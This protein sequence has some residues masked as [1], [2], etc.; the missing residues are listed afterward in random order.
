M[1]YSMR[2]V[3]I[4]VLVAHTLTFTIFMYLMFANTATC[5]RWLCIGVRAIRMLFA[6]PDVSIKKNNH[7]LILIVTMVKP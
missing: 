3:K 2:N 4:N 1:H 5:Y 7:I 6:G